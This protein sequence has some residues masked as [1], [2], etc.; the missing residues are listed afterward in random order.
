MEM[1][2]LNLLANL[3]ADEILDNKIALTEHNGE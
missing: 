3:I 2:R 1:E